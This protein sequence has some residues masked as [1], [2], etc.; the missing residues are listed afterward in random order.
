MKPTFFRTPAHFRDWLAKHHAKRAE[1]WV[2]FYRK[3]S[4]RA[5]ITWPESVDEA[6]CVG[7]I[8]GIRKRLDE[9]SYVIRFTPRKATSIWSAIN[10]RR[11]QVLAAEGR[12]KPPGLAAH[13]RRKEYRSG[14]YAYEQRSVDLPPKYAAML[15]KDKLAWAFHRA[16]P[17]GYRKQMMWRIVCAKTEETRLKRV[18]QLIDF[19]RRGE[20]ML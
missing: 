8:D 4:G 11:V 12:M 15:K 18:K 2:G 20:R 10:T 7:W 17:P 6:L 1:L 13:G 19:S 14:I 16:Q 3:D 5:S 9:T